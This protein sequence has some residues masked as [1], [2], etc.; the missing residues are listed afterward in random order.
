M[1]QILIL[2]LLYMKPKIRRLQLHE[3][4]VIQT[5]LKEKRSITSD[6]KHHFYK[7][8]NRLKGLTPTHAEQ[9]G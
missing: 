3:W 6:S 1:Q 8:P 4:V 7:S 2:D 5:L 9:V